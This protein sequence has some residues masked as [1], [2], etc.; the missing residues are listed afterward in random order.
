M[1][2]KRA[3]FLRFA[4]F[5][6]EP[7]LTH[8]WGGLAQKGKIMGYSFMLRLRQIDLLFHIMVCLGIQGIQGDKQSITIT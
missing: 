7:H 1:S 6:S 4:W 8:I 2:R 3:N 5:C